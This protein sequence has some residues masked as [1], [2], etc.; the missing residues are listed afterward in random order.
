MATHTP[1][2]AV[3][4]RLLDGRG[5]PVGDLGKDVI[6]QIELTASSAAFG[7]VALGAGSANAGYIKLSGGTAAAIGTAILGAGSANV[8]YVKLS[9][10]TASAIG[11]VLLNASGTQNAAA[12]SEVLNVGGKHEASPTAVSDGALGA[13]LLDEFKRVINS[14]FDS[15]QGLGLVQDPDPICAQPVVEK[16]IDITLDAAPTSDTSAPFYIGDADKVA[17]QIKTAVDWTDSD[18]DITVEYTFEISNDN[19]EW[20]ECDV[21]M[22]K[23]GEDGPVASITHTTGGD[24]D[25]TTEECAYL[26]H[27][28]GAKW[29]RVVATATNSD[30]NDTAACEVWAFKK[31]G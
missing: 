29:L 14:N 4:A 27:G 16:L 6:G 19:S 13:I 30:A 10:S 3:Y 1:R 31:R 24:S 2:E 21:V 22:S 28:F 12:P 23:A 7:T 25:L 8:G 15:A 26:A 18:P 20:T 9:G 5:Q 17:F 11:T